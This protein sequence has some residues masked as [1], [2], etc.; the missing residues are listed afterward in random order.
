MT[1]YNER[2]L[3]GNTESCKKI[4]ETHNR[5][6]NDPEYRETREIYVQYCNEQLKD[7]YNV[8]IDYMELV[9]RTYE[10]LQNVNEHTDIRKLNKDLDLIKPFTNYSISSF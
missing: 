3:K 6:I 7:K 4:I 1:K 10:S 9:N 2:V 5:C 8:D